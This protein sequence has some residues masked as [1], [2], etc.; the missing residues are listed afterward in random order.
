MGDLILSK[1]STGWFEWLAKVRI[2][3][4][5]RVQVKPKNQL[6]RAAQAEMKQNQHFVHLNN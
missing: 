3:N 5:G 1:L 6:G 4:R 2:Q